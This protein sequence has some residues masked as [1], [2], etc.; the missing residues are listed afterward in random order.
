ML[1]L[2]R[3]ARTAVRILTRPLIEERER[4]RKS[5]LYRAAGQALDPAVHL[6]EAVDW[7][8][9]AQD[10]G[11]DRG[12]SYGSDFGSG[13]LPSYPETTGYIIPTFLALCRYLKRDEFRSRAVEMGEWESAVQLES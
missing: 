11:S 5:I 8:I 13:F 4:A 9:R 3:K 12:V 2:T 7:L 1:N 6:R 10:A